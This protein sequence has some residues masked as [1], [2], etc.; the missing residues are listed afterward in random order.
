MSPKSLSVLVALLTGAGV[1]LASPES[2][3]LPD[4]RI[5]VQEF[6]YQIQP[7]G[8]SKP[9][10]HKVLDVFDVA[11]E[12][13]YDAVERTSGYL[14]FGLVYFEV[15]RED[16]G[17]PNY[18]LYLYMKDRSHQMV[19]DGYRNNEVPGALFKLTGMLLER[20]GDKA[21]ARIMHCV[22]PESRAEGEPA[23]AEF[24]LWKLRRRIDEQV[25]ALLA[26]P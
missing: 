12:K 8:T 4:L 25:Q 26:R 21:Y 10:E 18:N 19:A 24:D 15:P 11:L 16:G 1:G 2:P 5:Q 14:R 3:A 9:I 17:D 7:D 13:Q 22:A 23:G 20:D 6:T